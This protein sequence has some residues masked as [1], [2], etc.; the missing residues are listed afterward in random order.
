MSE[1]G[2]ASNA[3]MRLGVT[4]AELH[5]ALERKSPRAM[6]KVV[7]AVVRLYG[8]DPTWLITGHYD[9]AT[10]RAALNQDVDE[11]DRA[12]NTLTGEHPIPTPN[13]LSENG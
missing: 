4:E 13:Q 6:V 12:L 1:K 3:A 5:A 10:H 9:P 8:L 2:D 11:I 7:A